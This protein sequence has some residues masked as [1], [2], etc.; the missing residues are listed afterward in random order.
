MNQI[1]DLKLQENHDLRLKDVLFFF[2]GGALLVAISDIP[3]NWGVLFYA[4]R[5]FLV[6]LLLATFFISQRY[7]IILLLMLASTGLDIVSSG[8][9]MFAEAGYSTASIWQLHFGPIHAGY[10]MFGCIFWQLLRIQKITVHPF[11]LRAIVWFSTVPFVAAVIYGGFLTENA[12]IEAVVDMRFALMLITSIILFVSYFKKY[13]QYFNT[14]LVAFIG[15]LLARH[16]MDFIYVIANIGPEIAQDVS[17]GSEDSAKG[18]VVLLIYLGM[19]LILTKRHILIGGTIVISSVFLLVAYGTRNLWITFMLG[20]LVLIS[21]LELRKNVKLILMGAFLMIAGI[22]LLFVVNPTTAE[23]IYARSK[24]FI[25]DRPAYKYQLAVESNILTRIEEV[26]YAQILNVFDSLNRRYAWFW[27]TGYGGYYE[28]KVIPFPNVLQSAFAEYSFQSG[29]YYRAHEFNTQIFLKFGFLGWLVI[30]SLWF[31]PGYTLFK[32][33]K[34]RNIF[35]KDQP[36]ILNSV[37]ICIAAFLPTG[38]LQ[39]F[40]SSKGLLINGM[41]IASCMAFAWKNQFCLSRN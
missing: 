17:R 18:G 1:N 31:V 25:E 32:I 19:V 4:A 21:L 37:M 38:M 5:G 6:I 24:T 20:L 36:I 39:T 30:V 11:V 15:A 27:G 29:E 22:W 12:R 40:W 41:I 28:D 26:R 14:L 7:A 23:I 13:P 9:G 33:F 35:V 10:I 34:S 8:Y 2:L 3:N 16:L